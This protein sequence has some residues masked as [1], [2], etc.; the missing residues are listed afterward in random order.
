VIG[1]T[2]DGFN[3]YLLAASSGKDTLFFAEKGGIY[4]MDIASGTRSSEP[5]FPGKFY[6]LGVNPSNGNIFALE[7]KGFSSNG[8]IHI[9]SGGGKELKSFEA[10]VGPNGVVFY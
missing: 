7:E 2:G 5:L 6:G 3:P 8:I 9:I 4:S 1:E 10:G